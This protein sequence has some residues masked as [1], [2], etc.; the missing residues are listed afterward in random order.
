M[1]GLSRILLGGV[2]SFGLLAPGAATAKPGDLYV[3]DPGRN[4]APGTIIR[5][6]HSTGHQKVVASG[7]KLASPD[8][9]AFAGPRKLFIADYGAPAVFRVNPVSGGVATTSQDSEFR[10]PTDVAIAPNGTLYAVDP[11]AGTGGPPFGDG[12]VFK[13]NRHTGNATIVSQGHNFNG[14]PLGI[15]VLPSGKL[16][17]TDQNAG[18]SDSGALLKIDPSSGHQ[19]FVTSGGNLDGGYGL[20]LSGDGKAAYV[21]D[22]ADNQIVRVNIATGAQHVVAQYTAPDS[23]V[24]D[25]ALGLDGKLYAVGD[26]PTEGFVLRIGRK[27]GN[28]HVFTSGHHLGLPEGITVQPRG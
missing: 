1:R 3:G 23:Y 7:G 16:L 12:A 9:G 11:F 14:G 21:A 24:S 15:V 4:P 28:I 26:T 27:T 22:D 2:I 8:S 6:S 25:V 10:G 19:T 20:T 13:V 5:V 17:V 18:P